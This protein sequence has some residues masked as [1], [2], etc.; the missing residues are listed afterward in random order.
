MRN[1]AHTVTPPAI[2]GKWPFR[3]GADLQDFSEQA[4]DERIGAVEQIVQAV[5]AVA[6]A[7]AQGAQLSFAGFG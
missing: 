6:A 1:L 4:G 3:R 5:A 7:E 2:D